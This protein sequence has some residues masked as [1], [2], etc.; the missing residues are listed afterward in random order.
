M[1]IKGLT[2]SWNGPNTVTLSYEGNTAISDLEL[3]PD[4]DRAVIVHFAEPH[5][6]QPRALG[7]VPEPFPDRPLAWSVS[8]TE[9]EGDASIVGRFSSRWEAEACI[10]GLDY[11]NPTSVHAGRYTITGPDGP[12]Y[13]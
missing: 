2:V 1:R 6:D 9:K 13:P 5:P 12:V 3:T 8:D 4:I 10:V 11:H 7:L